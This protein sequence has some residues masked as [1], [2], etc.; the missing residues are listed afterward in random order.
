MSVFQETSESAFERIEIRGLVAASASEVFGAFV[1]ADRI[2]A[3]WPDEAVVD[4]VVGGAYELQWPAMAWTL[5]GTF[6][7]VDLDRTLAFTWS[8]DHEPDTPQRTVRI[9][10]TSAEGGTELTLTHG[11]YT[12]AD[13]E[14]RRGHVDGWQYFL[15]RLAELFD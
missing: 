2:T 9:T 8:W 15:G 11:E 7:E 10:L 14:E 1:D 6:T 12:D 13:A 3:W 5:R 4:P